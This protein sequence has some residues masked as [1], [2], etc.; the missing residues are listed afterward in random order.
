MGIEPTLYIRAKAQKGW[1]NMKALK[2]TIAVL[3]A[4]VCMAMPLHASAEETNAVYEVTDVPEITDVIDITDVIEITDMPEITEVIEITDVP[5]MSAELIAAGD[6]VDPLAT[7]LLGNRSASCSAGSSQVLITASLK[8]SATMA[9][10]G[11]VNI[12]IYRSSNNQD[13]SPF[14]FPS[15][16]LATNASSHKLDNF[17]VQVIGGYYYYVSL[18]YHVKES[19]WLF[20]KTEE[21]ITTTNSVYV[22]K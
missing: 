17:P 2:N 9:E 4:A 7:S 12:E 6:T 19:G 14:I 22:P 10:I 5:E 16:Q 21:E 15:D 1:I 18:T 11:F 8:S 3:T 13:W 20:P